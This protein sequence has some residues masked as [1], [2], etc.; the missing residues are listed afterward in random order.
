MFFQD[1]LTGSAW[2][3][4]APRTASPLRAFEKDTGVQA[5]VGLWDAAGFTSN[6]DACEFRLRRVEE[7]EHGRVTMLSC[8]GYKVLEYF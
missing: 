4:R 6:G 2:G 7:L 1:G 5:P 3:N 8:S